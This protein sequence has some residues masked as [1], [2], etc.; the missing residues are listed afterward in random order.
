MPTNRLVVKEQ[1]ATYA[2]V[3]FDAAC[4]AG[5]LDAVLEVRDQA[6]QI[7]AAIRG[8]ATLEETLKSAA[9]TPE[10]RATIVRNVFAECNPALV[11][12]LA[13]MAERAE[14]DLLP[15]VAEGLEAQLG[16]KLNTVV[17]DVTTA[18]ELDDHL[19]DIIKQKAERE[20]GKSVV[21]NERIDK[22]M[23]GGIIMSTTDERIDASLLT[24][25]ENARVVLSNTK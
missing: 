19:R 7:V 25:V 2:S 10:Q 3:L 24:Q 12:V 11:D 21:L 20:L 22:S 1:V 17:V 14:A 15:R 13:V 8:N 23:I 9:Y 6:S 18:V 16:E 4:D 5:G